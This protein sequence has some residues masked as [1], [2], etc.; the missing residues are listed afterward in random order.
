MNIFSQNLN[1]VKSRPTEFLAEILTS[2]F[3]MFML[4]ETH[5]DDS[6]DSTEIFPSNF[7]VYRC[8]RSIGTESKQKKKKVRGGGVLIAIDKTIN[9]TLVLTG[10]EFGAELVCVSIQLRNRKVF[11]VVIYIRPDSPIDVYTAHMEL[12]MKITSMMKREDTLVVSGD[13][14]LPKLQW[15]HDENDDATVAIPLNASTEKETVV[16]DACHEMSSSNK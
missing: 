13:F 5:L 2:Y 1:G 4:F 3:R 11:L 12:L 16:L 14:N 10:D 7:N 15:Y 9:S 8:D 6:I